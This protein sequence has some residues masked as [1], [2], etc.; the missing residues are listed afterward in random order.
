MKS[1]PR[2][3]AAGTN[4]DPER[5]R[6]EL[7]ALLNKHGATHIGV[8]KEPTQTRVIFCI[9]DRWVRQVVTMPAPKTVARGPRKKGQPYQ[10]K[11]LVDSGDREWRRR[12]RALILITRA[13][14]ELIAAGDSTFEREFLADLLLADGSTVHEATEAQ[15]ADG[16]KSGTTP[17]FQ[18][19]PGK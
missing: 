2:R 17:K 15:L 13:K 7:E 9:Q 8:Y 11:P 14:L 19:G 4:I 16:Y 6:A 3:Y 18:L 12:W 1:A 10:P 5:S